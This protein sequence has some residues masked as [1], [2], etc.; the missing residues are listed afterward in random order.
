[1]C[2]SVRHLA[3]RWVILPTAGC[4][5]GPRM[6]GGVCWCSR[7]RNALIAAGSRTLQETCCAGKWQPEPWRSNTGSAAFWAP[8]SVRAA[9]ALALAAEAGRFDELRREIFAAQP[10]AGGAGYTAD[11]LLTLGR[12]AGIHTTEFATAVRGRRYER[13]ARK[14]DKAFQAQNPQGT[15][16]VFLDGRP[17]ASGVLY[18]PHA[19]GEAVRS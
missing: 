3:R 12:R 6:H 18:D 14:V 11:D 9:N 5:S 13:W 16:G 8:G 15:P 7:I 1:V 4:W 10:P 19:L 2:F 17:I